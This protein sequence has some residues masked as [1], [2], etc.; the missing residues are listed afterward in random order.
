MNRNVWMA[1]LI[2]CATT[3]GAAAQSTTTTSSKAADDK[4]MVTVTGCLH[5]GSG[6]AGASTTTASATGS[7]E[8]ILADA[9]IGRD[10]STAGSTTGTT[11]TTGTT[12]DR[13]MSASHTSY[14]LD[15][16]D[17]ELKNHIGHRI[18][19][20]GTVEAN[21]KTGSSAATSTTTSGSASTRSM[22]HGDQRLK[23]SSIRMI[24]ADC[25]AK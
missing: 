3:A 10:S 7:G 2:A 21:S 6:A 25:S 1:A 12:A 11:G 22:D 8:Y 16:R 24:A 4:N 19:V 20:T 13:A 18:E 17:S 14:Q 9:M 15:G 5:D 23:V